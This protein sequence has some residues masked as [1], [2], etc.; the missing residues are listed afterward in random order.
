MQQPVVRIPSGFDMKEDS[1]ELRIVYR[2][3]G[4]RSQ[5]VLIAI[6]AI[7][8]VVGLLYFA[9]YHPEHLW[10][11][12]FGA[13]WTPLSFLAGLCAMLYFAWFAVWHAWGRTVFAVTDDRFVVTRQLWGLSRSRSC[14]RAEV[15]YLK[16]LH[17]GDDCDG[18]FASWGV[19]IVARRS[20]RLLARQP[21]AQCD[22]L[23]E[24]LAAA[25]GVDFKPSPNRPAPKGQ[26]RR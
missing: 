2:S 20:Y 18:G 15:Q 14:S 19:D 24:R 17:D 10:R 22:W 6:V 11:T 25:L 12:V 21:L 7:A 16:Q 9:I 4:M 8:L 1:G 26:V 13:W 23:G 3:Q 5:L